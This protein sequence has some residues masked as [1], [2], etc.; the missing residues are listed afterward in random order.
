MDENKLQVIISHDNI[1]VVADS[2]SFSYI[3]DDVDRGSPINLFEM[4]RL[5]RVIEREGYSLD[6]YSLYITDWKPYDTTSFTSESA[7][8]SS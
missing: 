8:L 7:H 5:M 6:F 2:K 1:S 4:F 3:R